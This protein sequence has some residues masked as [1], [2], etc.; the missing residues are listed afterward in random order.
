[1]KKIFTAS[2]IARPPR[3]IQGKWVEE[4]K[5]KDKGPASFYFGIPPLAWGNPPL[6]SRNVSLIHH[7]AARFC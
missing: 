7:I 3:R 2:Q 5:L 1:M 6:K 4:A